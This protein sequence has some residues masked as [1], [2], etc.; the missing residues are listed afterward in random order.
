MI[1]KYGGYLIK[2]P[3]FRDVKDTLS[4]FIF[5]GETGFY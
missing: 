5:T 4:I 2:Y 1:K 3:F